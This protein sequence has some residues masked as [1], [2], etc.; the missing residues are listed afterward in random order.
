MDQSSL[1]PTNK[2]PVTTQDSVESQ[3]GA[4][5]TPRRPGTQS[6]R[7]N[8]RKYTRK[9]SGEQHMTHLVVFF[10]RVWQTP[11]QKTITLRLLLM[12]MALVAIAVILAMTGASNLIVEIVK[13]WLRVF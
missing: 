10:K 4:S 8:R 2:R 6:K 5:E 9:Q 3:D 7:G 11:P 13:Y 12:V 1:E